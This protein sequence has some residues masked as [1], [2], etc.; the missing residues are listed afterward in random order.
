MAFAAVPPHREWAD[1]ATVG[2]LGS[3]DE[4]AE[5]HRKDTQR[6]RGRVR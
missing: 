3:V 5:A 4:L 1:D 2:D 6:N